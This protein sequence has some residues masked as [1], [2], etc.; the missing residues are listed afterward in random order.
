MHYNLQG[1]PLPKLYLRILYRLGG[2]VYRPAVAPVHVVTVYAFM[3]INIATAP[4]CVFS[5]LCHMCM[6]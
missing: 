6:I 3:T 4:L 1:S 2:L 5:K